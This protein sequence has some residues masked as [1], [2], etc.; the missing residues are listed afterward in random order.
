MA[1]DQLKTDPQFLQ[2]IND[3]VVKEFTEKV[4]EIWPDLTRSYAGPG[5]CTDC[6]SS[7]IPIKNL[8]VVAGGRFREPYYWDSYWIIEGLLRTGGAFTQ[9]SKDII[10]NFLDFIEQFGFIPNGGRVY[11]LNRSQPPLLSQMIRIYIE[12][13]NDTSIL[14]RALPLLIQE[15]AFWLSNRTVDITKDGKSYKLQ[16]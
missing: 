11:Y 9:I 1:E 13:T 8:C 4:I 2:K 14:T 15:H 5:N 12:H 16:R 3:S 7:F 10:E 6:P